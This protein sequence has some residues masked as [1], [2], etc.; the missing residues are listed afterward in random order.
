MK[1]GNSEMKSTGEMMFVSRFKRWKE[2]RIQETWLKL[3]INNVRKFGIVC[4][5]FRDGSDYVKVNA[6]W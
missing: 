4:D 1:S 3:F 6:N 5:F 2:I